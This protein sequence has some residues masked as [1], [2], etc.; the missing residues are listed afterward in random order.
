VP[1]PRRGRM[2]LARRST[3]ALTYCLASQLQPATHCG[4]Q[5]ARISLMIGLS[6]LSSA[7][8]EVRPPQ[9][10][11]VLHAAT[12]CAGGSALVAC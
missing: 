10:W 9:H 7:A 1:S 11:P 6:Y 4:M 8:V 3:H 2:V 12:P 5:A